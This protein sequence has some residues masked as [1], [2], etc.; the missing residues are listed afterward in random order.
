M[1]VLNW[2]WKLVDSQLTPVMSNMSAA[3]EKLLK[4]DSLQL[5]NCLW[6]TAL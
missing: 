6:N 1:D 2:G 3:P 4:D 5:Q